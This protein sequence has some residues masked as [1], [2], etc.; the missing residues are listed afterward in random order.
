[1]TSTLFEWTVVFDKTILEELKDE[2]ARRKYFE[3]IEKHFIDNISEKSSKAKNAICVFTWSAHDTNPLV[4]NLIAIPL[5]I[6]GDLLNKDL[7]ILTPDA[8]LGAFALTVKNPPTPP[9]P[10]VYTIYNSKNNNFL[11]V[12][13]NAMHAE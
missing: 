11:P 10:P 9:P 8:G 4:Y 12:A 13:T 2:S 5:T 1:M 3:K 6:N 7:P